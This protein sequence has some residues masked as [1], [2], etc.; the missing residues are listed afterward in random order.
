MCKHDMS[1]H[2][3]LSRVL[4]A[5]STQNDGLFSALKDLGETLTN[6]TKNSSL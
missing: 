1:F 2:I 6:T 4:R 5:N 3:V